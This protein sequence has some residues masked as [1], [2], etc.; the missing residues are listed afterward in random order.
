MQLLPY[1]NDEKWFLNE[2]KD[3]FIDHRK[4]ISI[5]EQYNHSKTREDV[6]NLIKKV[7]SNHFD[8]NKG[9]I[10]E[11][12][13]LAPFDK[14]L[15]LKQ[16][17]DTNN[18]KFSASWNVFK[19]MYKEFVKN[20]NNLK[21]LSKYGI[22]VCPYCNESFIINR[23]DK[24]ACQ[25]DHFFPKDQYPI[26][27]VCLYNLVPSCYS[28]N[29]TKSSNPLNYSP[30][31]KSEFHIH[32]L[33]KMHI[34]YEILNISGFLSSFDSIEVQFQYSNGTDSDFI[35]KMGE[36][37]DTLQLNKPYQ[38]HKDYIFEIIKKG[39]IYNKAS[40]ESLINSFPGLF[41]DEEEFY[42]LIY[43]NFIQDENQLK[44]PLSKLT[45]DIVEEVNRSW[46]D[47]V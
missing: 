22:N 13:V 38:F 6:T 29:H 47:N 21:L 4:D 10:F 19:D 14:I 36:D 20:K 37:I 17:I 1:F 12:L 43:G 7:A 40:V 45:R 23:V 15:L 25:L 32:N 33:N 41:Y 34:S 9:D 3:F 31:D 42:T 18:V 26:F 35:T 28:C 24:G 5:E 27:A 11:Q 16:D 46:R 39:K 2:L 8:M 30:H 44:R